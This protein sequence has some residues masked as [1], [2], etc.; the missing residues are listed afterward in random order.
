MISLVK[1]TPP[2]LLSL[3]KPC[4]VYYSLGLNISAKKLMHP[5]TRASCSEVII[6]TTKFT[7]LVPEEKL[8]EILE[9]YHRWVRKGFCTK[10]DLQSLLGGLL[11][12]KCI[13]SSRPFLNCMLNTLRLA[14]KQS[15]I[16]LDTDYKRDLGWFCKFVPKF[17]MAFSHKQVFTYIQLDA[18]CDGEV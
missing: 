1:L 16:T 12:T 8:S 15:K 11:Y 10:W 14:D 3:L 9:E 7:I 2:R 6:D 17:S 13:R 4:I 5:T 18:M